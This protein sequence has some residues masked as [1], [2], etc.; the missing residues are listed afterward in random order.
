MSDFNAKFAENKR[1][2][3]S[4]IYYPVGQQNFR[5]LREE[6]CVYVDKSSFIAKILEKIFLIG[7]KFS[8]RPDIL[9]LL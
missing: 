4:G 9:I 7:L 3:A 1:S 6:E 5:E 2:M 8:P